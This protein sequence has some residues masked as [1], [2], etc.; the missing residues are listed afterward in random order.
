V[1]KLRVF[2]LAAL[3]AGTMVVGLD[4]VAGASNGHHL[5]SGS[6][7]GARI[8]GPQTNP[9]VNI[10]PNGH[11]VAKFKPKSVTAPRAVGTCTPGNYSFS[12]T[13]TTSSTQQLTY[14]GS[15]FGFP[16]PSGDNE[17][18]C[19]SWGTFVIGLTSSTKTLTVTVPT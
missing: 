2:G 19:L 1:R 18:I 15:D 16:I 7:A 8:A 10:K 9:N 12:V 4:S 13:N 17:D 6:A 3:V 14:E 11:G 5:A